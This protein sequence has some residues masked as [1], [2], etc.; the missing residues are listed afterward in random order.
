MEL[1]ELLQKTPEEVKE[2]QLI[3]QMTYYRYMYEEAVQKI[4]DMIHAETNTNEENIL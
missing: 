4:N 3:E 2:L 1:S